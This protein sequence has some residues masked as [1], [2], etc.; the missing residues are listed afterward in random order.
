M[1]MLIPRLS[2]L[3]PSLFP[4]RTTRP[5]LLASLINQQR[6]PVSDSSKSDSSTPPVKY[7]GAMSSAAFHE[8]AE[9]LKKVKEELA[10][11]PPKDPK[12]YH[13]IDA[14]L[15]NPALR[16]DAPWG[17][18]VVRTVYGPSSDA[19]WAQMLEL[20]RSNIAETLALEDQTDLLPRHELTGI[21]DEATLAGADSSAVRRAF[22]AW[23]AEDLPPRLCDEEL[24]EFGGTAQVRAKLLSNDAHHVPHTKHPVTHVPPQWQ[25]CVFVDEDC[26]RSLGISSGAWDPALKILTTDW[27]LDKAGVAT[28]EFT[29]DWDGGET[30]DECEEVGWM[31][32]DMSDYVPVYDRLVTPFLRHEYYQRSYKGWAR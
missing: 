31:Y 32:M 22:R 6:H 3:Q 8:A 10:L 2:L 18:V 15:T 1:R 11:I 28:E 17:F 23:V 24:E 14:S 12:E 16:P 9:T 26:L 21:E 29:T 19:P 27:V 20:L 7:Q 30:N 5:T 4:L 13:H 25:F